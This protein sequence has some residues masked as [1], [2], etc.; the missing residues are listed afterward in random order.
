MKLKKFARRKSD[1]SAVKLRTISGHLDMPEF[2]SLRLASAKR[3]LSIAQF[4]TEAIKEKCEKD[5]IKL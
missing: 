3:R 5:G 2:L 1:G 4:V